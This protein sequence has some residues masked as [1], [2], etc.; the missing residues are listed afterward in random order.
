MENLTTEVKKND[1]KHLNLNKKLEQRLDRME[2][3]LSRLKHARMRSDSLIC[4]SGST[5]DQRTGRNDATFQP[6]HDNER[7]NYQ[8]QLQGE[9]ASSLPVRAE[10]QGTNQGTGT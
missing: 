3:D 2:Q 1:E 4:T 10:I 8:N 5:K 6:S 9:K 7:E